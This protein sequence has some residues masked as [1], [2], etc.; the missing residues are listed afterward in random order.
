MK[1]NCGTVLSIV[2]IF[3]LTSISLK[4]GNATTL[5]SNDNIKDTEYDDTQYDELDYGPLYGSEVDYPDT[6]TNTYNTG[7]KDPNPYGEHDSGK[8]VSH[9]KDFNITLPANDKSLS[10][11]VVKRA[12]P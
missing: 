12:P 7:I 8:K 5:S 11:Q 3:V 4:G 10:V 6:Q 2:I 1:R 9:V